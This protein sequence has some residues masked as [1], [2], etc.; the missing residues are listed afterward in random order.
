MFKMII[1]DLDWTLATSKWQI[2]N[3]MSSLIQDLLWKYK[4]WVIS[5]WDYSQY[6]KQ[7]LPF[8]WNDENKLKNMY[9]CPTCSTKMYLYKNWKWEKEYSL[10]FSTEEKKHIIDILNKAIIDLWLEP[11]QTWWDL[12]EDRETQITYAWLWQLA[13]L[14]AKEKYD[15]TF[16]KRKKIRKYILPDLNWFNVLIWW[17]TCIDIT[18]DWV[19]KAY[20]VKKLMEVS[21]VWIDEII[22]VWDAIFPWW[23][24]YPPLEIWITS[25]RVF[26][27]DDTK[28]FIK[29]L[30]K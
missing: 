18:R 23:N 21:W 12:I 5:W 26:S 27:V 3:E 6:K 20:W 15:P 19:D 24:D 22:F 11:E 17:A 16:E 14:E 29:N 25:K 13:P 28:N 4:V 1:F 30:L 8:L 9:A 2:D 10:D 7:F